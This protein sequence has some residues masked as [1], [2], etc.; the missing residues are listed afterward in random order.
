[1]AI[2]HFIFTSLISFISSS[3]IL[4][5]FEHIR[6]G[7]RGPWKDLDLTTYTDTFGEYWQGLGEL[8]PSGI[9][10][11]YLLGVRNR[12]KYN[13]FISEYYNPNEI[14][15]YSTNVNRTIMSVY[16]HLQGLF[17][18]G[19]SLTNEQL[20]RFEMPGG[21]SDVVK[22]EHQRLDLLAINNGIEV[23]PV[24]IF[25]SS[26]RLFSLNENAICPGAKTLKE[27]TY[28]LTETQQK[29]K[30]LSQSFNDTFGEKLFK[31]FNITDPNYFFERAN[32]YLIGDNF[33]T[34]YFDS[35]ELK[36]LKETGIDMDKLYEFAV[37]I[38]N[39][40]TYELELR[41]KNQELSVMGMSPTFRALIDW[42]DQ[43]IQ[44]DKEGKASE[45]K[46][47]AP[48][49]VIYSGHDTTLAQMSFFMEQVFG[50]N[51]TYAG[52]A[53]NQFFDL[54]KADDGKYSIMYS[55]NDAS[56]F[57][58][59]Y[60]TFKSK[61]LETIWTQDEINEFCD[62]VKFNYWIIST[63]VLAG[64]VLILILLIIYAYIKNE[65]KNNVQI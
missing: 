47:S 15:V 14:L 44:L 7:A 46:A 31:Y 51:T 3:Q 23:F 56:L 61:I 59:E 42:M 9:R 20:K 32:I 52:F 50:I 49:M 63:F 16:S 57:S 26:Q 60:N 35:R 40:D 24:H 13:T 37:N 62:E 34:D 43:R 65:K 10:Q 2:L 48:K 41:T 29:L 19:R 54:M 28:N 8:T 1:M 27:K 12:K 21:M 30:A 17:P 22:A 38:S 53:S 11:H 4:F 33:L 39:T 55:Y 18:K 45:I 25:D 64:A 5:V 6:H 58:M 36:K